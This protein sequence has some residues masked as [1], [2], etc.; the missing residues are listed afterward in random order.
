VVGFELVPEPMNIDAYC[1]SKASLPS[2]FDGRTKMLV[3]QGI[4]K[5]KN[6]KFYHI[7][8]HVNPVLW[9]ILDQKR[10]S[11]A[12]N[13][14]TYHYAFEEHCR[15]NHADIDPTRCSLIYASA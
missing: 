6:D 11:L 8:K 4:S 7:E 13:L 2:L 9:K 10:M 15:L 14:F 1:A 5:F 3:D 12:L